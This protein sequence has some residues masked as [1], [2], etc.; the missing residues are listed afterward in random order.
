MLTTIIFYSEP[1][2]K[3]KR[4]KHIE[5]CVGAY[6]SV[7]IVQKKPAK[8]NQTKLKKRGPYT[9][10]PVQLRV[11][12]RHANGESNREIARQERIGRDTVGR[13]LSQQ[14]VYR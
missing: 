11:I 12:E 10:A 6:R 4:C 8:P 9:P 3:R 14:E 7:D 2:Q 13:I 1:T 5:N